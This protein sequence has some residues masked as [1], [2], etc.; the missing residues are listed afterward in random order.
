MSDAAV[1]HPRPR[2]TS[3]PLI[4]SAV[5]IFDLSLGQMLWSRRS[6][7]L[8]LLLGGPILIAAA[9]RVVDT[10]YRSGFH[11]NG[12][13]TSGETVFG[14][15]IWILYIR[16]IV[17]VLGVFFG[18][19]LIADEV[20]DKTITYL[21]TRP[22]SRGAVLLGKYLAYVACTTL[23]VLPSVVIVFFLVVP[24]GGGRIA[25]A[26]PSLLTDL[27]MLI[28]GLTT[29]GAVFA[30]VGTRVPR[31]LIV[32]LVF[33]FGWEPA[34]LVFPGYL[35]RATVMYYL[36][37]L[38]SHEMPQDSAV[39]LL[40]QVFREIPSLLTSLAGLTVITGL[41]LW[42]AARAVEHKEYI[43]EQ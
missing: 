22:I 7:F 39:A 28:A 35:K 15:M 41:S 19:A 34:V 40:M 33:A 36:Q 32:G 38:V 2:Q 10:L 43:L 29:Y 11:I 18:T 31:P 24:T 13:R 14:L 26:F 16:F 1:T 30:L 4:A 25:Q 27:G 42:S 37:A 5:R 21:F 20:E 8:G 9:L 17:P 6:V 23:L 12:A 3:P